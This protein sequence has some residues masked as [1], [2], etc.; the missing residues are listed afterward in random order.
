MKRLR[1]I[2]PILAFLLLSLPAIASEEKIDLAPQQ[3]ESAKTVPSLQT[4]PVIAPYDNNV[5]AS[6]AVDRNINLFTK[7]IRERFTL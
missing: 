4:T 2:L 7:T 1:R 3:N 6:R 5:T